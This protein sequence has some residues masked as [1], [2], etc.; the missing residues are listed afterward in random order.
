M[1]TK[2]IKVK[3]RVGTVIAIISMILLLSGSGNCQLAGTG[4]YDASYFQADYIQNLTE[5]S[6]GIVNPALL[7]RVNQM[8]V[9]LGAYRWQL[10]VDKLDMG[11]QE[12]SFLMPVG[13]D[14]TTGLSLVGAGSVINKKTV[15]NQTVQDDGSASFNDMWVIIHG[16]W[17]VDPS[18]MV[19]ANVKVRMQ[20]QFSDGFHAGGGLDLGFYYNPVDHFR[21][22]DIGV[23][24]NL[25]DV[26][27][28]QLSWKDTSTT[29]A[30]ST[31]QT[32]VTRL[33]VGLRYSGWNDRF[34]ADIEG[35]VDNA[36]ADIW[37]SRMISDSILSVTQFQQLTKV[38]RVGFNARWEFIPDI[39]FKAGWTNNAM[40][41]IG[42]NWN[43]IYPL[44][45]AINYINADVN[46]GYSVVESDRGFTLMTKVST[47]FGETR[48]Q[49]ESKNLYDRLI[50][51]PMDAYQEA[52]R[53]YQAGKYWDAA[54]AFGK[55]MAL[56]PNFYLNDKAAFYMGTSY[57][58]LYMNET[59]RSV[60]KSALEEYTTSEMRSKFLYGLENIDYREGKYEDALK[61]HAF[62]TNL[63]GES[64]IRPDADYLAGQVHFMRKNY[65]AAE[66]LL[67]KI[68]VGSPMYYYAQYTLA[69]VNVENK[70]MDEAI[71][72]LQAIVKDTTPDEGLQMLR[73]AAN[74]K[75]GHVYY[76]QVELRKAVDAYKKVVDASSYSD[77]ALLGTAWSWIKVNQPDAC[78]ATVDRL[79]SAH[80]ESPLVPEAYLLKGY[81]QMLEKK[82][83]EAVVSLDKCLELTKGKFVTD[84]ELADHQKAYSQTE[85]AFLPEAEKIR[86]NA[87]RKPTDKSI[88]ERNSYKTE[89]DKF[90]KDSKDYFNFTLLAQSH[91]KFFM[92]KDQVVQDAEYALAKATSM[93]KSM[94]QEKI[95]ED[96]KKKEGEID[97]DIDKLKQQLKDM[98]EKK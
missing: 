51:A 85:A 29:T 33:R 2:G 67:S 11:Y 64:E 71:L 83:N 7:Y 23:S 86:K 44:I 9:E 73:D 13:L 1:E 66:Q 58:N 80:A 40:P 53:L 87:M 34:V 97:T 14:F 10:G 77:E 49:R 30:S 92:R 26:V 59:A 28:V 56:Y 45:D 4:G 78:L 68:K 47:D 50:L 16:A 72:N 70:K 15:E 22:G 91:R 52:M 48:E 27:P 38:F 90:S 31:Q 62:I 17:R 61:N 96:Q 37:K 76:E 95:I 41:Y 57:K 32:T 74:V 21:I 94:G 18:F 46:L 81:G 69:I 93:M 55:V 98:N 75:L 19:G 12:L 5:F 79:L 6:A 88:E 82:Y 35:V 89:Y 20:D 54:F 8:K 84:A 65:N 63:Y 25:Q 3:E 39:W 42:F 24:L 43:L 60:F 36:L